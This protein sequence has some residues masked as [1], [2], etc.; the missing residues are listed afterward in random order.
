MKDIL[1]DKSLKKTAHNIPDGY[2]D[3]LKGSLKKAA[4]QEEVQVTAWRRLLPIITMAAMF[5][6]MV[7]IGG[8]FLKQATPQDTTAEEASN[9]P[10]Y[11]AYSSALTQ[12]ELLEYLIY[13]GVEI[14][15]FEDELY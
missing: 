3:N 10:T 8:I 9:S 13:T 6:L 7:T 1:Q 2:F 11:Y 14:E 12:D 4:V 15:E 5:A